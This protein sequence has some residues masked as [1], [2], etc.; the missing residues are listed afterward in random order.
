MVLNFIDNKSNETDKKVQCLRL[1][2]KTNL[3]LVLRKIIVTFTDRDINQSTTLST[4]FP[5]CFFLLLF[6]FVC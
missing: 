3:D 4:L 2:Q 1:S 6:F 5:Y